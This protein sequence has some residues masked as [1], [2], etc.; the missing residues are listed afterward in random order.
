M[1]RVF[2]TNG[3]LILASGSP[4]RRDFFHGLG[5]DFSVQ[6]ADVD[7]SLHPGEKPESFVLRLAESKARTV[8]E[9]EPDSWVVAADTVVDIDGVILGKPADEAHA[10]EMLTL[11]SGNWH[12]VWSGFCIFQ[13]KGNVCLQKAVRTAVRFA[14]FP[15]EVLAAYAATGEPLDK[16]GAYGIQGIGSFLV[17][18]INGSYSNIVGLPLAE[19]VAE[20][21]ALG[22]IA[23]GANRVL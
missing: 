20:L 14:E 17:S 6:A 18:E 23:S 7:E 19:V 1:R 10:L 3:K 13:A 12:E 2:R 16:A 9:S 8:A 22:V 4:R 11:L 5:L 21:L 15:V